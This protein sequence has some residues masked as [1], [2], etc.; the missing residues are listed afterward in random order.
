MR[1]L[2]PS[3]ERT[4]GVSFT[5]PITAARQ[6]TIITWEKQPLGV[7]FVTT[8]KP[9]PR[10]LAKSGTTICTTTLTR[11]AAPLIFQPSAVQSYSAI[12]KITYN[13]GKSASEVYEI[14][15]SGSG[16]SIYPNASTVCDGSGNCSMGDCNTGWYD[17]NTNDS[18]GCEH[19]CFE[20]NPPT[21]GDDPDCSD[22]AQV[23][24]VNGAYTGTDEQGTVGKPFKTVQDGIDEAF[25]SSTKTYVLIGAGTYNERLTLKNGVNLMGGVDKNNDWQLDSS[26]IPYINASHSTVTGGSMAVKAKSIGDPTWMAYIKVQADD[27][28]VVS[29]TI[30]KLLRRLCVQLRRFENS[31]TRKLLRG[32]AQTER[33]AQTA[34]RGPQVRPATTVKTAQ[35]AAPTTKGAMAV[36]EGTA[37]APLCRFTAAQAEGMEAPTKV[38]GA[39]AAPG[40]VACAGAVAVRVETGTAA[41][42]APVCPGIRVTMGLMRPE[43]AP[44]R[45]SRIT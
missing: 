29:S 17:L 43:K 30:Q 32:R 22:I 21:F 42:V 39:Q 10:V 26:K 5:N 38:P 36:P 8:P 24:F 31:S 16:Q 4:G 27:G 11:T 6:T 25:S 44:S 14:A 20:I 15:L 13:R 3:A 12:L 2:L 28:A 34:Q 9:G 18:D 19:D 33:M 35:T 37:A 45:I 23:V 7:P 1:E 40:T 41:T